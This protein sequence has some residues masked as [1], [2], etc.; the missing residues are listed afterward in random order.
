MDN[1]I[2]VNRATYER[3]KKKA[4]LLEWL[5]AKGVDNWSGYSRPPDRE[6]YDTDKEYEEAYQQGL[7]DW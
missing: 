5:Q 1:E 2:L 6:D 4:E 3:M 7:Y